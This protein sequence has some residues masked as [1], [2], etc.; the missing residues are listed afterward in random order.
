MIIIMILL[1]DPSA[2]E[3]KEHE[4][5]YV[6]ENLCLSNSTQLLDE[7]DLQGLDSCRLS[8]K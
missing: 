7:L 6:V 2:Y 3:Y 4:I 1:H 5:W 8:L